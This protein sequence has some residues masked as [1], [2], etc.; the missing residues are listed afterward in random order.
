MTR[1]YLTYYSWAIIASA[2]IIFGAFYAYTVCMRLD[3]SK[4]GWYDRYSLCAKLCTGMVS[5]MS[6]IA[7][8]FSD[9]Y[10]YVVGFITA[11]IIMLDTV[12]ANRFVKPS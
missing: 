4:K 10:V 2:V 9:S 8:A 11:A 1:G 7:L 5:V 12:Y 3:K 6:L